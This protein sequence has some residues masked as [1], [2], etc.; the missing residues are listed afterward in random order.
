MG[1]QT[2]IAE[3]IIKNG[4]NYILAVKGN[5]GKLEEEVHMICHER[6]PLFDTCEIEKGHGRIETRRCEVFGIDF[7]LEEG[8]ENWKKLTT[9]IKI[10]STREFSDKTETHE[11]FY[12]SSLNANNEFNKYIRE[13]WGVENGLHWVLD[14]TFR[15]D[16]QRKRAKH[17]DK[18]FAIVRKIALNLLKKD[19]GKESLRSKR[20]KAAW[21]KDYLLKLLKA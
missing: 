21:N 12:I 10:T 2:A 14:M 8:K 6:A 1:T 5:Q 9:V 11:R 17:A 15:E 20:L 7:I 16:E 4:G 13:H 3:K 18:N 19:D